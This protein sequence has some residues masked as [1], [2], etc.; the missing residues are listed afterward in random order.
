[1]N[2]AF[3]Y[4][5]GVFETMKV[6]NAKVPFLEFHLNRL[7]SSCAYLDIDVSWKEISQLINKA[8]ETKSNGVL[9]FQVYRSG[10][11][12][13]ELGKQA[14][15]YYDWKD[16]NP[17]YS[18]N[19]EGINLGLYI[20]NYKA[21]SLLYNLKSANYLLYIKALQYAQDKGL[22]DV[23]IVNGYGNIVEALTS[24]IVLVKDDKMYTPDL[25]SGCVDG[26]MLKVLN[27]LGYS[28]HSKPFNFQEVID[29]DA[30]FLTNAVK[31]VQ[32]VSSFNGLEKPCWSHNQKMI[33]K[34]N[35][36]CG[37]KD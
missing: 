36:F 20:E 25:A 27:S 18:L 4:G 15:Y 11:S 24:N 17:A 28:I 16:A 7:K 12:F 35:T 31:G 37:I 34:L 19:P 30:V 29:A 26:V 14:E 5:D 3:K 33:D 23:L 32:W 2:R 10:E 21:T 6:V 1:M 9:R 22:D 8:I 13:F